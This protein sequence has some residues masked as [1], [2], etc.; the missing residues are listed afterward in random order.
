MWAV[1]EVARMLD[2]DQGMLMPELMLLMPE[3]MLH[4][5][6]PILLLLPRPIH[7]P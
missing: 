4:G 5:H 6:Q 2:G 1:E 3:L 7:A